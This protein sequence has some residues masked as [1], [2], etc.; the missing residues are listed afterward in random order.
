MELD[1][2]Q[3]PLSRVPWM[4]KDGSICIGG[5]QMAPK[6]AGLLTVSVTSAAQTRLEIKADEVVTD[7]PESGVSASDA[8][9]I[10][11]QAGVDACSEGRLSVSNDDRIDDRMMGAASSAV[12]SAP[13]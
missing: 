6:A 7:K 4:A 13:V 2:L 8:A 3:L 12:Q 5:K 10:G 1:I 11:Q 9:D